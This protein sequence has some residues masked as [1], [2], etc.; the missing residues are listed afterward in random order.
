MDFGFGELLLAAFGLYLLIEGATV[1]M[2]PEGVQRAM[3]MIRQ[4]PPATL[5]NIGLGMAVFGLI[6]VWLASL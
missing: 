4:L 3:A 2:F 5:R 6:L 1:A